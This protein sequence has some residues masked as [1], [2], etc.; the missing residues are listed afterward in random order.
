MMKSA[1][2]KKTRVKNLDDTMQENP[3]IRAEL[4]KVAWEE[5]KLDKAKRYMNLVVSATDEGK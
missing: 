5:H 1:G 3:F 2:D 4:A